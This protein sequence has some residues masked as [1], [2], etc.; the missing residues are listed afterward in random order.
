MHTIVCNTKLVEHM[1]LA[2]EIYGL[3]PFC[4][5]PKELAIA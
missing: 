3:S 4:I 2:L 5:A 1:R